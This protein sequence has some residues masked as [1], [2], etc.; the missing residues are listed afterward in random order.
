MTHDVSSYSAETDSRN[1]S[2]VRVPTV[3]AG[4]RPRPQQIPRAAWIG[5][6][7]ALAG[8][9]VWL[10]RDWLAV[11]GVLPI[12]ITTLPCLAMCL[13]GLCASGR[14]GK[15]CGRHGNDRNQTTTHS[16]RESSWRF[17]AG[18]RSPPRTRKDNLDV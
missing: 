12:L 9:G 6:A 3:R 8:A 18:T 16:R 11:A 1:E 10:G 15:S 14:H 7:V 4:L 5:M 2:T 17:P 13:L